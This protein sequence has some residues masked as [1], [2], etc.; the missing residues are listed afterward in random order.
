MRNLDLAVAK[1]FERNY[2]KLALTLDG[3]G[4]TLLMTRS[5]AA[6]LIATLARAIASDETGRS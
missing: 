6:S 1:P 5:V 2:I 3:K 4:E